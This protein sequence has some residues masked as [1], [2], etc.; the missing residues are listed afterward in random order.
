MAVLAKNLRDNRAVIVPAT[1]MELGRRLRSES[2]ASL[3]IA[4][5]ILQT[6]ILL[7]D[8][9]DELFSGHSLEDFQ[10]FLKQIYGSDVLAKWIV[11]NVK[12]LP[13]YF[14]L[15]THGNWICD[16]NAQQ[17]VTV[18]NL[19]LFAKEAEKFIEWSSFYSE[20][21]L[22]DHF[23][24]VCTKRPSGNDLLTADEMDK[25]ITIVKKAPSTLR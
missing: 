20:I 25:I 3:Q 24:R 21:A 8:D 4:A 1:L 10:A 15:T 18:W 2:K 16:I 9:F 23:N 6:G 19:M 5:L 14:P 22:A 7:D 11:T 13:A 17:K 12:N